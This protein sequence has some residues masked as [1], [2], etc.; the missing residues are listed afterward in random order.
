VPSQAEGRC[1]RDMRQGDGKNEIGWATPPVPP[2][3]GGG[4]YEAGYTRLRYRACV[5]DC[6]GANFEILEA[7]IVIDQNAP[8]GFRSETCLYSAILHEVGHLL[9]LPHLPPPA[10]MAAVTTAC[11]QAPAQTDRRALDQRYGG[12]QTPQ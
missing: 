8:R 1:D 4:V 5:R 3:N 9:G 12:S 7:D 10:V 6:H 2:A 11:P